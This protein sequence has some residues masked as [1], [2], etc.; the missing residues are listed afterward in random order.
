M[1]QVTVSWWVSTMAGSAMAAR[2][3]C[4]TREISSSCETSVRITAKSSPPILATVSPPRTQSIDAMRHD[5]QQLVAHVVSQAVVDHLEI[6]EINEQQG[7]LAVGPAGKDD[8]LGEPVLGQIAVGQPG[9]GVVGGLVGQLFLILLALGD[10]VLDADVVR[11]LALLR[12]APA[13]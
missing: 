11:D 3:L 12:C 10:V 1:L 9:Q 5:L 13:K 8:A 7:E 4:V 6:I 2:I